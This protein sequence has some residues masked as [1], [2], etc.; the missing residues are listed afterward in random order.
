MVYFFNLRFIN[1]LFFW[2]KIKVYAQEPVYK[3]QDH[4]RKITRQ[5]AKLWIPPRFISC[6]LID[7]VKLCIHVSFGFVLMISAF[8]SSPLQKS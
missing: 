3:T 7:I 4:R 2:T 6:F 5:D 8:H 1:K